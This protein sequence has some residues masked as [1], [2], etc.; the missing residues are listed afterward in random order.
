MT[1][2]EI[3][4]FKALC[5]FKSDSFDRSLLRHCTPEVLGQLF[6]NR[7]A[8]I[9][10][11]TLIRHDLLSKP[12]REF[13]NSLKCAFDGNR[14]MTEDFLKCVEYVSYILRGTDAKAALLKGAVLCTVY[15]RGCRT[16][17]DIDI[18]VSPEDVG[19]ISDLLCANGFRQGSIMG[20][21]FV[22]A[23]R[24]EIIESRML[25]GETVPFIKKIGFPYMEYLEL[26]INFSLDYKNGDGKALSEMLARSGERSIG[27]LWVPT[28]EK[29]DFIIHLCCHLHKEATTYL[30][31]KMHRD[32]SLY[33]YSDI[34]ICCKGMSDSDARQLFERAY[35][36]GAEKQCAFA[37]MQTD[38]LFGAFSEELKAYAAR[39]LGDDSNA[40]HRVISPADGKVFEYRTHDITKRLFMKNRVRDLKEA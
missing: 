25:R 4:L 9:A 38:E 13:R 7:M 5:D 16:S 35:Q 19:V 3:M 1:E 30:W 10:C 18:L 20:G 15:P 36:L 39:A 33:K 24:R 21:E 29:N 11:E 34:Y 2:K 27:E 37:I 28:L 40:L 8:G 6:Y 14:K 12:D 32:M 26:D 17:N 31:V 23:T 22:A